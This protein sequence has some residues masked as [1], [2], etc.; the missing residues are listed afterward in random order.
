M[1]AASSYFTA[2]MLED[3]F[4]EIGSLRADISGC[5]ER[6]FYILR[7]DNAGPAPGSMSS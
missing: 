4:R 6:T 1:F 2:A 3:R 7:K 5:E